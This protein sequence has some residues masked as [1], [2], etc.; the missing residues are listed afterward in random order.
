[1][2]R[3]KIYFYSILMQKTIRMTEGG[4]NTYFGQLSWTNSRWC[5]KGN[6]FFYVK[7]FPGLFQETTTQMMIYDVITHRS[8]SIYKVKMTNHSFRYI[9]KR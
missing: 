5:D 9:M 1:M 3:L 4:W 2:H 8:R 6:E 7:S